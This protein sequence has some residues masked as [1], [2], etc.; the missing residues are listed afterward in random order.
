MKLLIASATFTSLCN[1]TMFI[2]FLFFEKKIPFNIFGQVFTYSPHSPLHNVL[3]LFEF[4]WVFQA[5]ILFERP[6]SMF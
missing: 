4:A 5:K 1:S 3:K 2:D 6:L